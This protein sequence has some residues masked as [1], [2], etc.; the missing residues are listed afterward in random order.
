[1]QTDP[2][3]GLTA[4]EASQLAGWARALPNVPTV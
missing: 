1:V 4:R 2:R 3:D